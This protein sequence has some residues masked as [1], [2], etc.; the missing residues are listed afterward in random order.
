MEWA[1]SRY[2]KNLLGAKKVHRSDRI[3][4]TQQIS[5]LSRIAGKF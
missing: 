1:L 5:Q 4:R 3:C 2:G